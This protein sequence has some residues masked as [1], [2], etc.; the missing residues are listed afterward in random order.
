MWHRYQRR[1]IFSPPGMFLILRS[2]LLPQK[3]SQEELDIFKEDSQTSSGL[4]PLPHITTVHTRGW[5][6]ETKP[7]HGTSQ[8]A[9]SSP[10]LPRR[11]DSVSREH[12]WAAPT[13]LAAG[14]D[15]DRERNQQPQ[16]RGSS[17]GGDLCRMRQAESKAHSSQPHI[18]LVTSPVSSHSRDNI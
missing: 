5:L 4:S 13:E 18:L 8:H 2:I 12:P 3:H 11:N 6:A 10:S 15:R 1:Q 9:P 7:C 14:T 17:A 16:R